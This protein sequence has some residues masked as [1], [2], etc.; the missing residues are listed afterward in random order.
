MAT[1][2]DIFCEQE[3]QKREKFQKLLS[4]DHNCGDIVI[5]S[6]FIS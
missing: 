3:S 6:V 4:L 1:H 5:N 2:I